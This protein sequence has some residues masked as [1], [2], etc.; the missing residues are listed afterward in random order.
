MEQNKKFCLIG[1]GISYS[2]SPKIHEQIYDILGV[3]ASYVIED[4]D[5]CEIP[6]IIKQYDGFNVTKPYKLVVR[7]YLSSAVDSVNTVIKR[8]AVVRGISTDGDGFIR[9]LKK[10]GGD[11]YSHY[12]VVGSGG[13]AL[14]VISALKGIG[15]N[16]CV[17]ARNAS[18]LEEICALTG[19]EKGN[20]KHSYQ[21]VIYCASG[22]T[23]I[24]LDKKNLAY[25]MDLRYDGSE[26]KVDGAISI[27]G[28]LML[29]SQAV[30]SAEKFL[31]IDLDEKRIDE[32]TE[33]IYNTL[34]KPKN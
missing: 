11:G 21:A 8:G 5:E 32:I 10:T 9:A 22:G 27:N 15:K 6:R 28:L 23:D 19:C 33:I 13:A 30:L 16:P 4:I 25:F 18:A 26:I 2:L 20:K 14:A 34:C 3:K 24:P 31:S 7:K 12:A 17:F 29:V 1:K